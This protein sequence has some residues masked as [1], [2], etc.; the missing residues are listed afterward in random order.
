LPALILAVASGAYAQLPANTYVNS[1]QFNFAYQTGTNVAVQPQ[2]LQV[3]NEPAANF[4]VAPHQLSGPTTNI[5]WL[6]VNGSASTISGT[7][8]QASSFVTVG[9][10][11]TGLA[12]G[13]YQGSLHLEMAGVPAAT[14]DITVF[15]RVS[16]SPQIAIPL[17]WVNFQGQSG[18]QVS[19][20]IPVNSTA[21]ATPYTAS[22]SQ[23]YPAGSWLSV[24]PVSGTTNAAGSTAGNVTLTANLT[25][26]NAGLYYAVV[27]FRGGGTDGGDVSLPVILTVTQVSTVSANPVK[28]DFAFQATNLSATPTAKALAIVGSNGANLTY[29]ATV[30]GD[31]RITIAKS[32]N[33]PGTTLLTGSTPETIYVLVNP[34]GLA[35][36][37]TAE[38]K[39]TITTTQN[40]VEVPVKVTVTNAPLVVASPDAVSFVYSLGA[41]LPAS[42]SVNIAGTSILGYTIS[43]AEVNGG[44]WLTATTGQAF[45]P[46]QITVGLNATQVQQ[47]AAG[48][49]TANITVTSPAAGNTP[50]VIPV[51]LT[52]SGTTLLTANPATLEFSGELNGRV[53]DRKTFTVQSTDATNQNY[54]L[55]VEPASSWLVLDKTTSATGALGDIVTVTVDPTKVTTAGKY[56]ADVVVTPLSTTTG[57]VGQRVHVTFNVTTS[58]SVTATP[59]RIDATQAGTAVPA[60]VTIRIASPVP[61]VVFTARAEATWFTVAPVQGTTNQDI[62]VTFAS[63]SLAPGT[64][65]SSITILPPGANS[66]SIPVH[67]V[68]Q[69][70]STLILS[71]STLNIPFTAGTTPPAG[72]VVGLTS[73]GT[74]IAFSAAATTS[75]GGNWLSV[76]PSSGTTGAAGAAATN[77]TITAN[78][79]GLAPGAYTGAVTVTSTNASNSPQTIAVTL[80]VTAATPPVLRSVESAARNELTLI[81]PGEILAIKGTNLGPATGV[82]GR[83]TNGVV[84]NTL[85]DV[86]VLFDGVPAPVLFARQDQ[87]NTVAPYFL[88][89]RTTTR[90]QIEYRGQRNDAA[91][92][93]VVDA[94]PG[95]FT[96]DATGRGPGA[97]L[98]QNNTVNTTTNPAR[99]GEVIVIYA[100]GEGQVRPSGTDGRITTGTVDTL[101]RPVL[102]VSVKL[103]GVAVPAENIFYAGSAPGLVA[104]ALQINVKIPETL[105]ITAQTQVP[106]EIQVG[107]TATS[108]PGVTVAVL[109]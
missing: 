63:G 12:V 44:D 26:V 27:N 45:T 50:L 76:I 71:Q 54:T 8:G 19:S 74:P 102:P 62:T 32:A 29:Q 2:I 6:S 9:V 51:T 75:T 10:N 106:V 55:R 33:P 56:E 107:A 5:S 70:A 30:S 35:A 82:V 53:P 86:R 88:F 57:A 43:E 105:N 97:I 13:L 1:K 3:I 69:S 91:E 46:G 89:G 100:S 11:P 65:D 17:Q 95:I 61:G 104:G 96:Q 99:R 48:T 42:Q 28:V 85:S 34:A 20:T 81:A 73:S 52:V 90:I 24:S 98:N 68:V 21:A 37:A 60:P 83:V 66:L 38:A 92:Y 67:L 18:T 23:Y 84:E 108:Q 101:P 80:V 58:T 36:G 94:A 40:S 59:V 22:V 15:L 4:T 39:I 64:Y 41:A 47:L 25:G 14:T 16:A 31:S 78:P 87:V 109:P 79:T 93:R 72:V 49:Y 7:T 77:L 103:N